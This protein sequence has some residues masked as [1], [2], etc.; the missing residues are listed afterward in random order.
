MTYPLGTTP[1]SVRVAELSAAELIKEWW[2]Q[3]RVDGGADLAG[4]TLLP[5][6]RCLTCGMG[7]FP[8]EVAGG[9][10]VYQAL[11]QFEWYYLPH[12]W[13]HT[14]ALKEIPPA[15]RVLEVGCSV[16]DFVAWLN[17]ERGVETEGIELNP[18]A[19]SE[20]QA[21]RRPVYQRSL[22]EASAERPG[23]CDV[24][25]CFQVLEYVPTPREFLHHALGLLK[26]G[27]KLLIA[28]PHADN[29]LK[30]QPNLL[31]LPPH[32]LT[33]WFTACLKHIE[34]LFD[35]QLTRLVPKPLARYHVDE[36]VAAHANHLRAYPLGALLAHRITR[37]LISTF[38]P[39]TPLPRFL[40]GQSLYA[41]YTS[42]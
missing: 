10:Y 38:L 18:E 9:P 36:Y 23:S 41:C 2:M 15:A 31:D 34:T 20:A 30:Y 1:N 26:S 32:P 12:R 4:H 7:F 25:C 21:C 37:K 5:H 33:R 3:F 40:L 8:P 11:Q 14:V 6:F 39:T 42:S 13:E 19:V 22:A 24:V 35:L 17:G 27:G 16:G 29:F 28:V